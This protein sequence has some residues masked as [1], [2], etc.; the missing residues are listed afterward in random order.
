MTIKLA[1]G[2][3]L[4]DDAVT[5]TFAILAIR[6]VGKTYTG[7]KMA[8]E[9]LTAGFQVVIIDPVGVWWGLRS[10]AD[11]SD[12]GLPVVVFGGDHA[13][14]PLEATAG[15]LVADLVIEERISVV[16]DLSHLRKGQQVSFMVAFSERLYHGKGPTVRRTPVHLFIDEADS[17]CPQ[18]GGRDLARVTGA[19]E[20]LVKKG[21]ARGIG[22][23][24]ITQRSAVLNKN[25]L[26]QVAVLVAMRTAS[27]Q[28]RAAIDAWVEVAGDQEK[29]RELMTALPTLE[30]G[31]AIVWAPAP[32]LCLF[33]RVKIGRARTFDSSATPKVGERRVEPTA[34]A[35]ID[36][37][38]ISAA[39]AE[40]IE[41]QKANDPRVLRRQVADLE[42]RLAK[43]ERA[44]GEV[45][46]PIVEVR[47][48]P[49]LTDDERVALDTLARQFSEFGGK[50]EK[51]AAAGYELGNLIRDRTAEASP[52]L[53][54]RTTKVRPNPPVLPAPVAAREVLAAEG[55]RRREVISSNGEGPA[56]KAGA[57][58]I[59][60]TLV[61]MRPVQPTRS[62]LAALAGF[63]PKSSTWRTY[64]S[65]LTREGYMVE[66]GSG[67]AATDA[68]LD[69]VGA[70]VHAPALTTDELLDRWRGA[71]KA[72]ARAMLD[73][74]VAAYPRTVSVDELGEATGFSPTSSTFR[75]YVSTL[76]RNGLAEKSGDEV[77]ASPTLFL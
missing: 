43:A 76:T 37:D 52:S 6:G 45:P 13:D 8:E 53:P 38:A 48:V 39:M 1:R 54:A 58:K 34:R 70:A 10:S 36:L 20:D 50:A 25:V 67:M 3:H 15:E 63:S 35:D 66:T 5:E 57:R 33:A 40:T 18:R 9:M 46:D 19:I 29:R 69:F 73:V 47:E 22:A 7:K 32:P 30:V 75:T 17:F 4:P 56:I 71:L 26:S 72:G 28:D 2:F 42:E 64:F 49:V 12:A 59:L 27:P 16:L 60:E 44:A 61:R 11:G 68:G 74:L 77:S 14:V 21:R 24:L 31:E 55:E 41:R 51:I 65:T 62:Q 23:T